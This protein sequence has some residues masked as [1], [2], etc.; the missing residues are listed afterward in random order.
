MP[1]KY[2]NIPHDDNFPVKTGDNLYI[3]VTA[4]CTW[5]YTDPDNCFPGG[6]LANGTY[7]QQTSG[8]NHGPY[9]AVNVGSVGFDS[10]PGANQPCIPTGGTKATGYT[11]VVS[12]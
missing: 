7:S 8:Q 1:D 6:L 3:H 10:P 11:I 5:C 4:E 2:L 12:S 9:P